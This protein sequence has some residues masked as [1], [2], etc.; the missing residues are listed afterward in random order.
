MVQELIALSAL[1]ENLGSIPRTYMAVPTMYIVCIYIQTHIHIV[2][3]QNI[4]IFIF[5][6]YIDRYNLKSKTGGRRDDSAFRNI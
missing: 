3:T 2:Y 4:S 5:Y 1:P 6:I